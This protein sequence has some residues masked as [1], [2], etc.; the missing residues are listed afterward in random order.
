M[1]PKFL[2]IKKNF[3]FPAFLIPS[4]VSQGCADKLITCGRETEVYQIQNYRSL[5]KTK[6]FFKIWPSLTATSYVHLW[7]D[8][9]EI[10][11][12]YPSWN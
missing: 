6:I 4:Q 8:R 2:W 12:D 10:I 7:T 11:P 9:L 1:L 3:C 5:L